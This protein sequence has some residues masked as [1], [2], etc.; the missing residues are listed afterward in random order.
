ME[1]L[2]TIWTALTTEN[3]VMLNIISIPMIFL[4]AL[5]ITLLFCT[6]L[7]INS[8]K[9]QKLIFITIFSITSLLSTYVVPSPYNTFVNIII[10]PILVMIIFKTNILKSI[11]AVILPYGIFTLITSLL[12]NIYMIIL[13][14]SSNYDILNIPIHKTVYSLILYT[15]IFIIYRLLLKIDFN[16][17]LLNKLK[18]NFRILINFIIGIIAIAIQSYLITVYFNTIPMSLS[19]INIITLFIYFCISFYSLL[20]TNKLEVTTQN[21]EEE[22]LY[23]KTLTILHDN[24]RGF[25]HD[26]NNI[27]QA[28]GGYISTENIDGL[29]EY[30]NELL[31]DCQRINN[32]SIL[33]PDIINNPAI[34][35]LLTSKY[36]TADELGIKFNL[37]VMLDLSTINMKIYE[38]SRILGIL[39]DNAIEASKECE[40]KI[41]NITIRNDIKQNRQLIII[42]NTYKN[43][44]INID[45]IF[46]KGFTSKEKEVGSHGLGLWEVRQILKKNNNL[47]LHTTKDSKLFK[48]QL[49]IY[50]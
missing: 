32:L 24:I 21:L 42:E 13:G 34:Y 25:K 41:I 46:D 33:N 4:E 27:V 9:K 17:N 6:I 16:I 5:L 12:I 1:F 39:I 15:T 7:R 8:S 37:E 48:Q 35:S 30:Y 22:K 36:H 40:E 2:Q 26:F 14:V 49:E 11:L 47:N 20:R 45:K 31:D 3:E 10:F 23:N 19:I 44:D 29:K 43:K 18:S 28:I 38:L 50:S